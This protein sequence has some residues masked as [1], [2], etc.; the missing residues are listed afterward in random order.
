MFL[1]II[2]FLKGRKSQFWFCFVPKRLILFAFCLLDLFLFILI[3][4]YYY[5]KLFLFFSFIFMSFKNWFF[6]CI[7][8]I[9][10]SNW[11]LLDFHF[12]FSYTSFCF[13][14]FSPLPQAT[15]SNTA[16]SLCVRKKANNKIFSLI[17]FSFWYYYFLLFEMQS[18]VWILNGLNTLISHIFVV[19]FFFVFFVFFL[20]LSQPNCLIQKCLCL[21]PFRYFFILF[22]EFCFFFLFFR[23]SLLFCIFFC[24]FCFCL[25]FRILNFA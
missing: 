12:F 20:M 24:L 19:V 11:C 15:A 21:F 3:F 17:F 13:T 16:R 9:T 2:L 22:L 6:P 23:K 10:M 7:L 5:V 8:N 1:F 25:K 4:Y 14:Y 18:E